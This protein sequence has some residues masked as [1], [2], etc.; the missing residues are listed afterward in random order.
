MPFRGTKRLFGGTKKALIGKHTKTREGGAPF[1]GEKV[2]I[3]GR[4]QRRSGDGWGGSAAANKGPILGLQSSIP[5]LMG[6]QRS[7]SGAEKLHFGAKNQ[8]LGEKKPFLGLKK[9]AFGGKKT[10]LGAENRIILGQG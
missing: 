10:H 1:W 9:S 2:G 6:A 8:H 3:W 5:G 7:H 4:K